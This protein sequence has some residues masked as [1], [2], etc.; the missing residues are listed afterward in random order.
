MDLQALTSKSYLS[1]PRRTVNGTDQS[2]VTLLLA[3]LEKRAGKRLFDQDVYIN[4]AG[5]LSISDPAA[6]LAIIM[7]VVSSHENK[8]LCPNFTVMG[9]VGLCGEIRTIANAQR[10]IN[11]CERLGYN[12]ILLP[13]AIKG[14]VKT[15]GKD[16]KLIFADTVS[17]A[18]ALGFDI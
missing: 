17:Q 8:T 12:I 2:R 15:T 13:K 18:L 16:T 3:V 9:E 10:R 14:R 4:V 7:A 5:G 11:E 1:I 6:D